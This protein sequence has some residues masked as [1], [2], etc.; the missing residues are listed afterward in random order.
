MLLNTTPQKPKNYAV[1]FFH[2]RIAFVT[3]SVFRWVD[4]F[5]NRLK[6]EPFL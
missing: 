4:R 5:S 1:Y 3:D 2:R 6:E